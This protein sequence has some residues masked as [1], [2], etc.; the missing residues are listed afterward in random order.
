MTG[1]D[2]AYAS[3]IEMGSMAQVA[4]WRG[5]FDPTL[6]GRMCAWFGWWYG[7]ALLVFETEPSAHGRD[8]CNEARNIGYPRLYRRVRVDQVTREVTKKLGWRTDKATRQTLVNRL[9]TGLMNG[10]IFNDPRLLHEMKALKYDENREPYSEDH[11]DTLIGHA[12]ALVGRDHA[13][14]AGDVREEVPRAPLTMEDR[15]WKDWEKE[16]A[17]DVRPSATRRAQAT[18]GM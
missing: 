17:G 9:R 7:G 13:Y 10:C 2:Y 16:A 18:G 14:S 6:W 1:G 5:L 4:S 15:Y 11:D 3:A 8:A 12:L